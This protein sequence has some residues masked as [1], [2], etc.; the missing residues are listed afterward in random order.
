MDGTC[1]RA[2]S[3][4]L[5]DGALAALENARVAVESDPVLVRLRRANDDAADE[6]WRAM[7][8]AP[9]LPTCRALLRGEAVP[10][11]RLDPRWLAE[12]GWRR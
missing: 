6:G 2:P 4:S 1:P 12:F 8:L 7:M 10:V 11:S 5:S 9:D 3:A